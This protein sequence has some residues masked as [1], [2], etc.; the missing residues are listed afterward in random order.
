[1]YLLHDCNHIK[2]LLLIQDLDPLYTPSFWHGS[3]TSIHS[4]YERLFFKTDISHS[5]TC[6]KPTCSEHSED[7]V[8]IST[9]DHVSALVSPPIP[10]QRESHVHPQSTAYHQAGE[11]LN[12]V[13]I[14]GWSNT[15]TTPIMSID[16]V[17]ISDIMATL[18]D[19]TVPNTE[20][21]LPDSIRNHQGST[22]YTLNSDT[23]STASS[24]HITGGISPEMHT[25]TG[26]LQGNRNLPQAR[27]SGTN[28]TTKHI[29]MEDAPNCGYISESDASRQQELL[30]S[31]PS[32]HSAKDYASSEDITE[33]V[34]Q[35]PRAI[36]VVSSSGY[37][38]ESARSLSEGYGRC[39]SW[40]SNTF[41]HDSPLEDKPTIADSISSEYETRI[42]IDDLEKTFRYCRA[43]SPTEQHTEE[44]SSD[45]AEKTTTFTCNVPLADLGKEELDCVKFTVNAKQQ[46][47]Y[48]NA[49]E[50]HFLADISFE[51]AP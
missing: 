36:S 33:E 11:H 35:R 2:V 34:K 19:N 20:K 45:D 3:L 5:Y 17:S 15:N 49:L 1:M 41:E 16:A 24:A 23:A 32:V 30:H 47:E 8:S 51:A 31:A 25:V 14:H 42:I 40:G 39:N 50:E 10:T 22:S 44:L 21:N 18:E 48:V 4:T 9:V 27:G 29:F 43:Y 6:D 38:S 12:S 28:T 46:Y 37:A 13:Q 7:Q 26:V